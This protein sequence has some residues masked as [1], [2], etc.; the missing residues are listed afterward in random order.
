MT[1]VS[2]IERKVNLSD[3]GPMCCN[4]THHVSQYILNF[5]MYPKCVLCVPMRLMGHT[6]LIILYFIVYILECCVG[7]VVVDGSVVLEVEC[8]GLCTF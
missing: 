5:I 1:L 7:G 3:L 6:V 2:Q 4:L 8:A